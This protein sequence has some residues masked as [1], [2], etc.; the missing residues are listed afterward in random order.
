MARL[1]CAEVVAA[2]DQRIPRGLRHGTAVFD[3]ESTSGVG[4]F[5]Y[6]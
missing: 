5:L 4:H 1:V 3:R 2:R 6:A